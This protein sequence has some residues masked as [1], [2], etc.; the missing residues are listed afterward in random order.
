[1]IEFFIFFV[2]FSLLLIFYVSALQVCESGKA[3]FKDTVSTSFDDP[4]LTLIY[5][6]AARYLREEGKTEGYDVIICDSSDPVG[7][8]EVYIILDPHQLLATEATPFAAT[9][10]LDAS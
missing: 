1:L 5:D 8:A 9:L 6:D 10:F 3:F 4:R 7:P 2:F